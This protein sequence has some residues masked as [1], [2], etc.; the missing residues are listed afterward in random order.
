MLTGHRVSLAIGVVA[1]TVLWPGAGRA[2]PPLH[3]AIQ[4]GDTTRA[5]ELASQGKKVEIMTL[6][7]A[8]PLQMAADRGQLGVVRALVARG[9]KVNRATPR[10]GTALHQAA[11]KGHAEIIRFL[12]ANGAIVD[13]RSDKQATPLYLAALEGQ[14]AAA[15]AL[16][17]LGADP[18]TAIANGFTALHATAIPREGKECVPLARLLMRHGADPR[19]GDDEGWTALHVSVQAADPLL[20]RALV[21]GG[22][23]LQAQGGGGLTPLEFAALR[24]DSVMACALLDIGAVPQRSPGRLDVASVTHRLKADWHL[25]RME[26]DSAAAE[27]RLAADCL[28]EQARRPVGGAPSPRGTGLGG[29]EMLRGA[30]LDDAFRRRDGGTFGAMWALGLNPKGTG[31]GTAGPSTEELRAEAARLRE[32]AAGLEANP[33][34]D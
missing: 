6:A 28:D 9:V 13:S 10:F 12:V 23:D 31:R 26:R 1:A 27:L 2:M 34:A 33:T 11:M 21:E 14:P 18:N 19:R 15:A 24:A 30:I 32:R 17:E 22:A 3:T 5:I 7:G 29:V 20:V 16:L 8:T 25:G 4:R